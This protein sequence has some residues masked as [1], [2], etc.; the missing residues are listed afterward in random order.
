MNWKT[1][2]K[3][4]LTRADEWLAGYQVGFT[5]V[6]FWKWLFDSNGESIVTCSMVAFVILFLVRLWAKY[7]K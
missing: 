4:D 5:T 3:A 6:I 1:K 2:L 7:S